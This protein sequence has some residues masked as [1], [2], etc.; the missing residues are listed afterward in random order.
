MAAFSA[1]VVRRERVNL[2][3]AGHRSNEGGADR[4][5]R[6]DEVAKALGICDELDRDHIKDGEAVFDNGG[7]LLIKALLND[8]GQVVT[9]PLV[10]AIPTGFGV[11]NLFFYVLSLLQVYQAEKL[12]A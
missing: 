8:L 10:C 3:Y 9:V 6:A 1:T 12:C 11:L 7:E 5:T 4:A 2:G